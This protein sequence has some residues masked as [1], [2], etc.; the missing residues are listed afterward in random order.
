MNKLKKI[1][2]LF[3]CSLAIFSPAFAGA[4][5]SNQ[6]AEKVMTKIKADAQALNQL[7]KN[8]EN[9]ILSGQEIIGLA[10]KALMMFMGAIMFLLVVYG[11][12]IWMTASGNSE[13]ITTA[14]N[15]IIWAALGVS[16]M[17]V[18]YM[19]IDFVFLKLK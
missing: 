14:K 6:D 16:V 18:S 19:A 1:I 15:I 13:K 8:K 9:K 7:P 12:V 11:G 4:A 17:S 2:L 10:I 5:T 3:I